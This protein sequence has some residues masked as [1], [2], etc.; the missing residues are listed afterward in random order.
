MQRSE[1]D[2]WQQETGEKMIRRTLQ[3]RVVRALRRRG[4][5]VLSRRQWGSVDAKVY[6][7]R[8]KNRHHFLLP[9]RPVDTVWQHITVTQPTGDFKAD[10][11]KVERIG[12][13]R[14][15][16]GCSYNFLIDMST[17]AIAIGQPMVAK[18]THTVNKKGIPRFTFDQNGVSLGIAVVGMPETLLSSRAET[19][20]ATLLHVLI[21]KGVVTPTFDYVPHS[22]VAEKDCP[23]DET[24]DKMNRI[25]ESAVKGLS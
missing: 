5:T 17:G 4:L 2:E 25:R 13:E 14:F 10:V 15:Q 18:G 8:R 9:N 7:W 24:R 1:R 6:A 20:I 11:R 19:S 3:Y 16:S 22:L 23:C 21:R 12:D